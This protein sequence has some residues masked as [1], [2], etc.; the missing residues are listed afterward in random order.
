MSWFHYTFFSKVA[1]SITMSGVIWVKNSFGCLE[2]T[3]LQ[4]VVMKRV[5]VLTEPRTLASRR[6]LSP[7]PQGRR[8]PGKLKDTEPQK[9]LLGT[10]HHT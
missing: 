6:R 7:P 2:L 1:F 8:G 4:R 5:E 9:S 10:H 3:R